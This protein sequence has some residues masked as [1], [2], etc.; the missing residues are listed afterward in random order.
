MRVATIAPACRPF[1]AA[2][3]LALAAW[4]GLAA[5]GSPINK[6]TAADPT[7]TVEVSNVAGSVTVTGWDRNEVEVTGELGDGSERLEFTKG[8][9][10]TRIKV[11]LP[12]RSY[13]VDDTQLIVKVPSGSVLSINTVSADVRVQNVQGTQRLQTVSGDVQTQASGEDV[14]CRTV[15]G[16]V[17][18]AGSGRKG[19]VSITT[20]SGDGTAS[21]VAGEV[22]GST[23]S[24]TFSLAVGETS[25]SRLRS[26]SGDIAL[27]GV[28]AADARVD[29]ESISG[30]VRLDLAGD[31]PAEYDISS[32]NGEIRNCFGPKSVKTSEYGPGREL[33][34]TE[35]SGSARIRIKTMN[36]DIGLCRK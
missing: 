22:N 2:A 10:L 7:G 9:K 4:P 35:G 28:L 18:I 21:G 16:D 36:G 1:I 23:V 8:P 32:F 13:N 3:V 31:P 30:D 6:R 20:V 25:R 5:A 33:R 15:S 29:I 27:R 14:E 26:T 12:N 11:V 24:G 17:N 19:V 34:F